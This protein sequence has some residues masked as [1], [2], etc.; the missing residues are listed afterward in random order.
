MSRILERAS[1]SLADFIIAIQPHEKRAVEELVERPESVILAEHAPLI[2]FQ[3]LPAGPPQKGNVL[4]VASK[5]RPNIAGLR[6]FIEEIWPKVLEVFPSAML[7]LVGTCKD[8]LSCFHGH[9]TVV[10]HG[11]VDS[12]EPFYGEASVVI[13]PVCFGSGLKIKTVEALA[14]GKALVTTP[15]GAEGL[16]TGRQLAFLEA[17]GSGFAE[18]IIEIL[19]SD[20]RRNDL[21]REARVFAENRFLP[22]RCYGELLEALN[23][24]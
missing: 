24:I 19:M 16:E 14:H 20:N 3:S 10:F 11:R 13:N 1:W 17:E 22:D 4:C 7:H 18:G 15:V 2:D 23:E 9:S 12:L 6:W 5:A 8:E 21:E